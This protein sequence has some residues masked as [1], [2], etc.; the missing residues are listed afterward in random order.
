MNDQDEVQYMKDGMS[1]NFASCEPGPSLYSILEAA[2]VL[3]ILLRGIRE[4]PWNDIKNPITNAW[5]GLQ[6]LKEHNG[7][8]E[9]TIAGRNVMECGE[10]LEYEFSM[11]NQQLTGDYKTDAQKYSKL[12]NSLETYCL[13]YTPEIISWVVSCAKSKRDGRFL[14]LGGGNGHHLL[15]CLSANKEA[16][17]T[18][19]D[20]APEIS[21]TPT[22]VESRLVVVNGDALTE[23]WLYK[24]EINGYDLI[25]LSEFLHCLTPTERTFIL[26]KCHAMLKVGGD[27]LIIEQLPNFRLDLRLFD[28]TE[29]GSCIP[30]P[31]MVEYMACAFPHTLKV[32]HLKSSISHYG[33]RYTKLGENNNVPTLN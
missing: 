3:P 26:D 6:L 13:V 20:K 11:M 25:I 23:H 14:D 21:Y 33:L 7:C 22:D 16:S 1:F 29:K 8:F 5:L 2:W 24:A 4:K 27:L 31:K 19:F 18:L 17:G 10:L 12:R 32:V 30:P 15:R 28:M 9:L